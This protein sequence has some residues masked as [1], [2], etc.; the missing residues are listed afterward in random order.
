MDNKKGVGQEKA[1]EWPF[2]IEK[3]LKVRLELC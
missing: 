3:M 2:L 1:E